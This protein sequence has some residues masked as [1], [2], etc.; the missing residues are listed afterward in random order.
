MSERLLK[1]VS[2]LALNLAVA[3]APAH[4][5]S[6][7]ELVE[8]GAFASA[9][10]ACRTA[11]EAGIGEAQF[12]LGVI[13]AVGLDIPQDHAAAVKWLRRAAQQGAEAARP[14]G[15]AVPSGWDEAWDAYRRGDYAATFPEIMALAEEGDARAKVLVDVMSFFD[16]VGPWHLEFA[17]EDERFWQWLPEHGSPA[18]LEAEAWFREAA[19]AGNLKARAVLFYMVLDAAEDSWAIEILCR[20]AAA[21]GEITAQKVLMVDS[22]WSERF[23]ELLKWT[24]LAAEQGDRWAQVRAA[25]VA[26]DN[27]HSYMWL[28]LAAQQGSQEALFRLRFLAPLMTGNEIAEAKRMAAKC[29]RMDYRGCGL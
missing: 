2:V 8:R 29:V 20:V 4:A 18:F 24:R 23:A 25:N 21:R 5:E 3:T 17:K 16:E 26:S 22:G 27:I 12:I 14:L 7:H 19:F 15:T 13:Y 9:W 28:T 11:A 1:L 10:P 6:C